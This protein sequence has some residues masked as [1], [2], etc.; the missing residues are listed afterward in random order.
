MATGEKRAKNFNFSD[1][2]IETLVG[3]VEAQK[4][5]YLVATAVGSLRKRSSGSSKVLLLPSIVSV[6]QNGQLQ[7]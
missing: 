6:G 1:T 3:E 7:N 4:L 5:C 2:D